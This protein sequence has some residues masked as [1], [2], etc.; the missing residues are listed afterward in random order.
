MSQDSIWETILTF[1]GGQH[2]GIVANVGA[3]LVAGYMRVQQADSTLA[4]KSSA[5]IPSSS[6]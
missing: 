4:G 1:I 3:G 2:A 6:P 5:R